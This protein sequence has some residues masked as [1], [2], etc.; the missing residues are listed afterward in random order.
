MGIKN[1][2]CNICLK[3]FLLKSYLI[4][5]LRTHTD[6]KPY[7]CQSCDRTFRTNTNLQMHNRIHEN[8]Y[9]YECDQCKRKF[10]QKENLKSHL[11]VHL[12]KTEVI[13][14]SSDLK[15]FKKMIIT[16]R[17]NLN[18][19]S[20]VA[21]VKKFIKIKNHTIFIKLSMMM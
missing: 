5:H 21:S 8:I 17:V 2:E 11:R 13:L 3:K 19:Y 14:T 4:K 18:F 1:F 6:E 20:N 9:L 10:R 15:K 12:V 7:K 16:I